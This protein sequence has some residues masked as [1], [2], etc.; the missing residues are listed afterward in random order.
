MDTVRALEL[1]TGVRPEIAW[2][3]DPLPSGLDLVVLPGGFSYGDYLRAGAIARF[4]PVLQGVQEHAKRGGLLLG[5]CN[6]FQILLEAGLLP[7]AMM[8]NK[9]LHFLCRYVNLR[10]ERHDL[11]FTQFAAKVLHIPVAHATGNYYANPDTICRLEENEQI[12]FR[13]SDPQ[14]LVSESTNCNGSVGSIA[15]ICNEAGNVLGMMPHP[16]RAIRAEL[17]S[18]DGL[19]IWKSVVNQLSVG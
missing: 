14:G 3:K 5:I 2:H 13:Y 9:S 4:S 15:G 8:Q 7:G 19:L 6:G 1:V 12:V 16:E 18:T 11:P 17:G 10:V